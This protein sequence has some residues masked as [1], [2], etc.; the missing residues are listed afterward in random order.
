MSVCLLTTTGDTDEGGCVQLTT[1]AWHTRW[2]RM[3]TGTGDSSSE[4]WRTAP[5]FEPA[6]LIPT[7]PPVTCTVL[8]S[9]WLQLDAND[10]GVRH[11]TEIAL[12]QELAHCTFLNLTSAILPVPHLA[13]TP[14]YARATYAALSSSPLLR[15]AV[16]LPIYVSS[17]DFC[18]PWQTWDSIRT[19]CEYHPRLSLA[20]DLTPPLP[21]L[22]PPIT[23]AYAAEPI[24]H[25]MISAH[26]FISNAKG[27]PVLPK[28]TQSLV[29]G[30]LTSVPTV[31]F[32][33]SHTDAKLHAEGGGDAYRQYLHHLIRTTQAREGSVEAYARGYGDFLQAPL[34]PLQDNLQ[35]ATYETFEQDPVKY[36]NYEEAIYRALVDRAAMEH[37]VLCVSGAGRGPLITRALAALLRASAK[38]YTLYAIEK[39]P[40]AYLVLQQTFPHVHLLFG[41]MR[42]VEMPEKVDIVISELLGS[43]GDNELSPECLDGV[44][45]WM[46]PSAISIP[47]SYTAHLSPLSSSKLYNEARNTSGT[48]I[49]GEIP[50]VVMFQAVRRLSPTVA[51]CWGFEHPRFEE[52]GPIKGDTRMSKR[53]T[54]S[55]MNP[56]LLVPPKDNGHNVRSAEMVFDIPEEGVLHGF[57]GYFEAVLYDTV[58]L[59]IH[60]DHKDVVSKDMLSW[61]PMFFPIRE[62]MY[63]AAHSELHVSMWRL[64]DGKRVWYEWCAEGY[65]KGGF[66]KSKGWRRSSQA[67]S[68]PMFHAPPSPMADAVETVVHGQ[69]E[70][71]GGK[72][73]IGQTGLHNVGGRSSWIGL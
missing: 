23:G 57:A 47:S 2:K 27:Y 19:L 59:S 13:H 73:K 48:G 41:D 34:Q 45:R 63:L 46:K 55:A 25:I 49:G 61:F 60:P 7:A 51:D 21:T 24:S 15:L 8:V 6:D 5:A 30:L 66:E 3:C 62:P 40:S 12:R 54:Q 67:S 35:N 31:S 71:G 37:I 20:L 64:T 58:G 4:T 9:P 39:N 53:Y 22:L 42:S 28:T 36:A 68:S 72:I 1:D 32:V 33:L 18:A 65:L 56:M 52:E 69:V 10:A 43:F 26:S 44:E 16:R 14:S 38:S 17:A 29:R 11:D 70:G 50:Y